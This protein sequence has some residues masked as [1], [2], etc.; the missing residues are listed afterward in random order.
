MR[1]RDVNVSALILSAF[2]WVLFEMFAERCVAMAGSIP[3]V[4]PV[5]IT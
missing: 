2:C 1:G 3:D 4:I 5:G